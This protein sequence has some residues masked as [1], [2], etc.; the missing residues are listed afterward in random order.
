MANDVDLA[1]DAVIGWH[2]SWLRA[3][4][5]Q[6]SIDADAWRAL[7]PSPVIYFRAITR[8]AETP[9]ESVAETAGA[10][11]DSW[12]R[13]DLEPFGFRCFAVDPWFLR[14]AGPLP[15]EDSPPELEIVR[16][17]TPEEVAE[18]E[19]VSVR[20]FWKEDA[21]IETGSTH[22]ATI[23]ADSRMINWIGRVDG[24][25]VAAAMSFVTDAAIG[26]FGV[27]TIA[28]ARRR[29][30]GTAMTR[31]AMLVNT[32]LPAVLDPSKE[33]E[34]MYER[35]GYRSVGELRKWGRRD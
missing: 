34:S 7:A 10:V 15:P 23:L 26:I 24:R 2:D 16:V 13:L 31:A 27:T 22:P 18:F 6:T 8:R 1:V 3:L 21:T 14:P 17:T 35:L 29:G 32:G 33:A 9:V 20:G 12:S 30:Y 25:P 4:G 19:L 28:S 5:C 11:C